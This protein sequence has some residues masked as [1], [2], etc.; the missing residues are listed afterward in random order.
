MRLPGG[1][2][3]WGLGVYLLLIAAIV[4]LAEVIRLLR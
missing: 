1:T 4:L 2:I 3:L